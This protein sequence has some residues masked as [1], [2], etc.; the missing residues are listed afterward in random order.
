MFKIL[1]GLAVT[2]GTGLVLGV[3]S[4]RDVSGEPVVHTLG[5]RLDAIELR[6]KGLENGLGSGVAPP[7]NEGEIAALRDS[8]SS[9]EGRHAERIAAAGRRLDELQSHLPRFIDVKVSARIREMED[10]LKADIAETHGKTLETF[11]SKIQAR[12]LEGIAGLETSLCS[13]S[14][15]IGDLREQLGQTDRNLSRILLT[16]ESL[17]PPAEFAFT[18]FEAVANGR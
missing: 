18:R 10:R 17:A 7:P 12:M 4:K 3:R 14:H 13:Q 9:F 16:L 2:L 5:P 8:I 15:E 1:T 11:M 6:M